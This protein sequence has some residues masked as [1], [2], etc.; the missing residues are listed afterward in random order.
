[1][2]WIKTHTKRLNDLRFSKL[3]AEAERAYDRLYMLAG[4]LDQGG[5]FTDD[6][7]KLSDEEIAHHIRIPTSELNKAIKELEKIKLIHWNSKGLT[8][9]NWKI[10]QASIEIKRAKDRERQ[11]EH[12]GVTRDTSRDTRDTSR[13]TRDT[14]PREEVDSDSDKI[15]LLLS[16][17]ARKK[18]KPNWINDA[19]EIA[20][21][22]PTLKD[23][24]QYTAGILRK[25]VL[26]G[27]EEKQNPT[28]KK[29]GWKKKSD[30]NKTPE[31]SDAQREAARRI[32]EA[33]REKIKKQFEEEGRIPKP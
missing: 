21:T 19:I 4:I 1:M 24:I 25:W 11:Q 32:V 16:E 27:R 18:L 28:T 10:E 15:L 3:S 29:A 33:Q 2:Q 17:D 12:R 7:R 22:K 26:N 20:K 13:D 5:C 23:P 9:D 14:S 8:L 6:G 31:Y 30:H